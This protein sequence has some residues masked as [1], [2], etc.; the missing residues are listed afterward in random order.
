MTYPVKNANLG[1]NNKESK[2]FSLCEFLYKDIKNVSR[3]VE[4]TYECNCTEDQECH[5]ISL[6]MANQEEGTYWRLCE[7]RAQNTF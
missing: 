3:F 5:E 4:C 7:L 1:L 6:F 2:P